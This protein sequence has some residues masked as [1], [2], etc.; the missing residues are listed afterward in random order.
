MPI[1]RCRYIVPCCLFSEA[2]CF[3]CKLN[4]RKGKER[5]S[6]H[7]MRREPKSLLP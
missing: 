5:N 6:H 7:R 2:M 4:C 3:D 1:Y